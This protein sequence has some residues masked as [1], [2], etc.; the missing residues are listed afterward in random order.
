MNFFENLTEVDGNVQIDNYG[1][2][3][4]S[5]LRSLTYVGGSLEID[6]NEKLSN[7]Y[8]IFTSFR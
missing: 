4:I 3:N 1:A 7:I 2:E 6:Q 5:G 8:V